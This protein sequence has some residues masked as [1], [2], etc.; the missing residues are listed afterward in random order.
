MPRILVRYI[1]TYLN[2]GMINLF[3]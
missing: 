2:N 1:I 3:F